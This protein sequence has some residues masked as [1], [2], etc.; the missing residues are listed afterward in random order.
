LKILIA[1]PE[2]SKEID[3]LRLIL[4]NHNCDCVLF[5]E[6][7]IHGEDRLNE[8]CELAKTNKTA[9]VT[10]YLDE[11]DGKDRA[12]LINENGIIEIKREKSTVDGPMLNPSSGKICGKT[13]GYMLCREIFLDYNDVENADIIFNPIGVGMFSEE[14]FVVWSGR[15]KEIARKTNSIV[16]GASHADGSY[17]NCGFSIPIS[18]VIDRNGSE[19]YISKNDTRSIIVD[20]KLKQVDFV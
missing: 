19:I 13:V 6:G 17:R 1:Q 2:R 14:Q 15:A 5:P 8:V 10:S 9:I 4:K 3:E 12:V 7:Y 18:F 16:I 20:L 11:V